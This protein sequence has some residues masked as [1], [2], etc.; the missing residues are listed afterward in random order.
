MNLK[1]KKKYIKI[2]RE[3]GSDETVALLDEVNS[4]LEDNFDNL[5]NDLDTEFVLEEGLENEL[6]SDDETLNSLVPE[7]KYHIVENPTI[8]K[9][10]EEVSCK[11]IND[12][13]I[14]IKEGGKERGKAKKKKSDLMKLNLIG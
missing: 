11:A 3:T 8:R 2:K 10:F 1:N 6:D 9:S 14:R 4:D 13:E 7:A 5:M 12:I